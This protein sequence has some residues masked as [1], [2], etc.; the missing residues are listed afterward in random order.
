MGVLENTV[1]YSILYEI[2]LSR[3]LYENEKET[4]ILPEGISGGPVGKLDGGGGVG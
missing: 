2:A 1:E 3:N 4:I